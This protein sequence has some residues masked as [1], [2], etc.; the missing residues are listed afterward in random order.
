[1]KD[2]GGPYGISKAALNMMTRYYANTI[3]DGPGTPIFISITPGWV[4]TD[5]GKMIG[6]P[7]LTPEQTVPSVTMNEPMTFVCRTFVNSSV[8][9]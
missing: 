5:M 6:D 8:E 3:G 2:R 7:P 4:Q 9:L 1:M